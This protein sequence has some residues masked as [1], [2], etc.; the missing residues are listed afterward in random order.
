MAGDYGKQVGRLNIRVLPDADKFRSTLKR[1]LKEIEKTL[2]VTIGVEADTDAADRDIRGFARRWGRQKIKMGVTAST[3]KAA[4]QLKVLTR[5]RTARVG[6]SV[7]GKSVTAAQRSLSG[8]SK[9]SGFGV[10]SNLVRD[11]N[12][13]IQDLDKKALGIGRIALMFANLTT[14]IAG[15]SVGLITIAGDLAKIGNLGLVL[16]AAFAGFAVGLGTLIVALKS[17][18]VELAELGPAFTDLQ[19]VIQNNFWE[20]AKQPIL[21]FANNV[22]PSLSVGFG[23][24][25]TAIGTQVGALATAFQKTL[26]G[27]VLDVMFS[28]LVETIDIVTTGMQPLAEALTTLGTVGASYLPRLATYLVNIGTAFND[29][30]QESAANGDLF[31]FI[32]EGIESLKN[33]ARAVGGF[34]GILRGIDSAATAAGFG[35][36]ASFADSLQNAAAIIQSP[37][38]QTGL[39][40]ILTGVNAGLSGI[41][42]GLAE[43][44]RT[45]LEL[46]P[47]IST[48]LASAGDSLGTLISAVSSALVQPEFKQGLLDLFG[49]INSAIN[50]LA[51]AFPALGQLFG[52]LGTTIG[53]FLTALGPLLATFKMTFAPLMDELLKAVQPLI[54]L[55]GSALTGAISALTPAVSALAGFIAEN[56]GAITALAGSLLVGTAAVSGGIKA[57][58]LFGNAMGA[59]K[60][61]MSGIETARIVAM[62]GGDL[63]KALVSSGTA[64]KVFAGIQ[65]AFALAQAIATG[66]VKLF[67]AALR[68]NPIGA[69]ITGI[70]LLVG[71]L[72]WFFTQTELGKSIWA[73]VTKF[74]GEAIANIQT[75]IGNVVAWITQ[76]WQLL[77]GILL[78][79]FGLLL[80]F[81]ITN[82]EAIKAFIVSWLSLIVTA[83]TTYWAAV[84]LV[85]QTALAAI[86]AV[87]QAVLSVIVGVWN[88]IWTAVGNVISVVWNFIVSTVQSYIQM[89]VNIVTTVLAAILNVWST[90]WTAIRAVVTVIWNVIR[91]I[92][93]AAIGT[94]RTI[95][96][97]VLGIINAI[98]TGQWDK[99]GGYVQ[100]ILNA[101]RAF[102]QNALNGMRAIVSTVLAGISSVWRSIWSGI[103][104]TVQ[105]IISGITGFISGLVSSI[106]STISGVLGTVQGLQSQVIGVFAG[107][108]SWLAESGRK[109]IQGLITGISGMVG[110]VKDA[111][112]NVM[113]AA[114]NLLPFSP[115]KEGPFSG[116]GWSLYSGRSIGEALA[117]GMEDRTA[118][119][120]ASALAMM[121]AI[122]STVA[123][124]FDA[125]GD[126]FASGSGAAGT[127][128]GSGDTINIEN[129]G[130]DP[131]E[132]QRETAMKKKQ[133][134][135][136]AGLH[137]VL[138]S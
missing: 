18:K 42:G 36:L 129:L 132:L 60:K 119:V 114:R 120:R 122:P 123:T 47:V 59:V 10:L 102:I 30:V 45:L 94:V 98:W 101:M 34:V 20:R 21:D 82:F 85:I 125:D 49:G 87:I 99:I 11:L 67:S 23:R 22:L 7:D 128:G 100:N 50:S 80:G 105:S 111:V 83:W 38:V 17:A 51:P 72:I 133:Q 97:N 52:Q 43:F 8:L 63:V 93:Q 9:L 66:A 91:S 64:M 110:R 86:G 136:R 55:F 108:G 39:T 28:K 104:S 113:S 79:P 130:Y 37:A 68:A 25:S 4:A 121:E 14:V 137:R 96:A 138:P 32:D 78:G 54:P 44:G 35:G 31:K 41:G 77:L 19:S 56:Q 27:G 62:Y 13:N 71:A 117:T 53:I 89:V 29:W 127:P 103:S 112:G 124:K 116:K 6:V 95:I 58:S 118:R 61:I 57:F 88:A 106:A 90:V 1:E 131:G 134:N 12:A 15:A 69:I 109:I 107:A 70:T 5:P 48:V 75:F 3:V 40:T 126:T 46:A 16:P 74:I 2:K 84:G 135:I 26:G 81:I 24:V 115:A 73:N 33:A 65:K 76:N 92:V